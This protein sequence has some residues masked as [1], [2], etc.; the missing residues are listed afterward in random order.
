MIEDPSDQEEY[1]RILWVTMV[2]V[3]FMAYTFLSVVSFVDGGEDAHYDTHWGSLTRWQQFEHIQPAYQFG[4]W[5]NTPQHE[6][7]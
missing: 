6:G 3:T 2:V 7:Q 5:L 1:G 4:R